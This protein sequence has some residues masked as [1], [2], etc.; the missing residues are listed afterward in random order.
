ML[1]STPAGLN[2]FYDFYTEA[3]AHSQW[4]TFQYMTSDGGYVSAD[5]LNILKTQMTT[6]QYSQEFEARFETLASRVYYAFHQQLNVVHVERLPYQPLLVGMDFNVDPMTAVIA[7]SVGDQCHVID[8]IVLANSNTPEMMA[9]INRRYPGGHG[10][11]H[12]DP[13]GN[14]RKTSAPVGKTDFCII[15]EAGWP[16]YDKAGPYSIIDRLNTVNARMCD[17]KGNRRILIAP[18]CR[19]LIKSLNTIT[20]KEGTKIPDKSS[21]LD[22]IADA[23]GYLIMGRFPLLKNEVTVTQVRL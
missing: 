12:P 9:E 20:Y 17:A 19:N 18:K 2:H 10:A 5:E 7:Q 15:K 23:L 21:G 16:I 6:K 4:A 13:T 8:E 3:R 14:A 22:H 1:I 11:V